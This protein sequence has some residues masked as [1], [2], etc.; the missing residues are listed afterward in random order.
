MIR[1]L[2]VSRTKGEKELSTAQAA[3]KLVGH[4]RVPHSPVCS[5]AWYDDETARSR[6]CRPGPSERR[7]RPWS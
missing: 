4:A 2:M 7:K 5:R 3:V 6:V 1:M